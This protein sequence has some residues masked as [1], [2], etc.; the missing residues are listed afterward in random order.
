MPCYFD[1]YL[2]LPFELT[3][4]K[5]SYEHSLFEKVAMLIGVSLLSEH[6]FTKLE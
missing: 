4:L 1:S 2:R 5:F 3:L 6:H